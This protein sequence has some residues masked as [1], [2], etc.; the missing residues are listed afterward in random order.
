MNSKYIFTK[1]RLG[2]SFVRSWLGLFALFSFLLIGNRTL[3]QV[4]GYTFSQSSGTFAAPTTGLV[5][6][7]GTASTSPASIF[8]TN[9][10]DNVAVMTL[11]FTFR[12]A[13]IDYTSV[14]ISSNGFMVFG[15]TLSG[16]AAGSAYVSSSDASGVYLSGTST[17]NGVAGF[18]LD[19]QIR[20]GTTFTATRAT[21]S[22]VLTAVSSVA[23]LRVGMR[24]D[25][26]GITSGAII[27]A[28]GATTV[29]LSI[30]SSS[31]GSGATYTPRTGIYASLSGSGSNRVYT[32]TTVGLR[33]FGNTTDSFDFQYV[34]NETS[35]V[36][37]LVFGQMTASVAASNVPI[38]IRTT[39]ADFRSRTTATDWS[40]TTAGVVNTDKCTFS[41][42][43]FPAS[44]LT[45]TWTPAALAA[46]TTPNLA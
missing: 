15:G 40:A 3:A 28:I 44:G 32:I 14:S 26:T 41:S 11:P 35:N 1:R 45:F 19:Q 4:S 37:S 43:I 38:G 8:A 33:R 10:D 42:T 2:S 13:G 31:T 12:F 6:T 21:G 25:G 5:G 36:V 22:N 18:N 16:N 46:C 30:N 17:N 24:I 27:T 23:G 34:L 29:T 7:A 9:F 20:T 39:T